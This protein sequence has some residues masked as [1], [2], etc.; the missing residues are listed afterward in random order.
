M[1]KKQTRNLLGINGRESWKWWEIYLVPPF[2]AIQLRNIPG[3]ELEARLSWNFR[4]TKNRARASFR[5]PAFSLVFLH[6][7][8]ILRGFFSLSHLPFL[9]FP[10]FSHLHRSLCESRCVSPSAGFNSRKHLARSTLFSATRFSYMAQLRTFRG[11]ASSA[12][13]IVHTLE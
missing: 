11:R 13:L 4:S 12:S 10:R 8:L 7:P 2:R 9:S 3:N 1:K 6:L 5:L